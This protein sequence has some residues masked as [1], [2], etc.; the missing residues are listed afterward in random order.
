MKVGFLE[1]LLSKWNKIG[2]CFDCGR[3]CIGV[4]HCVNDFVNINTYHHSNYVSLEENIPENNEIIF[5]Y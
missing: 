5:I 4:F 1:F 3:E 2:D